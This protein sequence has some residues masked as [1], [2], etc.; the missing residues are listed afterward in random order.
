[1]ENELIKVEGISEIKE[2]TMNAIAG[3]QTSAKNCMTYGNRLLEK[4]KSGMN[5][6]LDEEIR[7]FLAKTNTTIKT[8][9]ERRK[10]VTQI[11]DKIRAGF[12]SLENYLKGGSIEELQKMR[13]DYAKKKLE[14]A[15]KARKEAERTLLISQ[16]KENLRNDTI[17]TLKQA[18]NRAIEETIKTIQ[19]LFSSVTLNN[20]EEVKKKI[21]GTSLVFD[22]TCFKAPPKPD[23]L[24]QEE[25]KEVGNKAYSET[26]RGVENQFNFDIAGTVDEILQKF[27]SKIIELQRIE[28]QKKT[29]AEAAKKAAEELAQKDAENAARKEAERKAKEEKEKQ[30]TALAKN[31]ANVE[32][33][34]A[35]QIS[36]P[37]KAKITKKI[38]ITDRQGFM[39]I[40]QMWWASEGAAMDIDKLYKKLGFMIIAC[41]KEANKNDH[42]IESPYIKYVD[43]VKASK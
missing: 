16:T 17:E 6:E 2:L 43:D 21:Q 10:P 35:Q 9:N 28:E 37:I 29:D 19:T 3:N 39:N 5:D 25:Y 20:V 32:N 41:E 26:I 36:A 11:F 40:I 12:T 15:E 4:A 30:A 8:M 13:D 23:I 42:I 31:T 18:G 7:K 33:L 1:M 38:E 24:S 14:E 22:R 27:P 34:F